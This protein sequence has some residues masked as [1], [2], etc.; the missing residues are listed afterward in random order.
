MRDVETVLHGVEQIVAEDHLQ[1]Q[2][3]VPF[4]ELHD[5]RPQLQRTEGHWGV[6]AEQAARGRLRIGDRLISRAEL[7]KNRERAL[8]IRLPVLVGTGVTRRSIEKL[9][10]QGFAPARPRTC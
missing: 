10:P 5:R 1:L 2:V 7:G 8:E 3:R 4:H 6:D 9:Y